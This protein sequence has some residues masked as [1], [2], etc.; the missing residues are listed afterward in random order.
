MRIMSY[1]ILDGGT[2][3]VPALLSVIQ[4]QQPDVI[5]L[6]EAE[7]PAVVEDLAAR[8]EMDFVHA[9]GHYKASA[10]LS[11]FP[12]RESI[13]HA[14]LHGDLTK[15]LLEAT[16]VDPSGEEWKLGVLHLHAQ[17]LESDEAVRERE[18]AAVLKIFEADRKARRPHLL[19]GDFNSNSPIQKIDPAMCKPST[20]EA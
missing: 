17:A 20:R 4:T 12:I 13:N 7:D 18:I 1:N 14:L 5:G 9:P 6:V 2:G 11:R 8:L 3:R 16:V 10:L 19:A 15:S